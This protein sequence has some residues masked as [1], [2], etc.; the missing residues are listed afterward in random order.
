MGVG[1]HL[2]KLI[3]R[4]LRIK[5]GGCGGC[6]ALMDEMDA[7]GPAWVRANLKT[8]LPQIRANARKNEN[9]RARILARL[10]G[11]RMPIR[12]MVLRAVKLAEA[13]L[14]EEQKA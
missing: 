9:W 2:S 3:K 1:S 6:K 8:I 5:T 10:P 4:W 11:A 13:D 7:K 12:A 14:T